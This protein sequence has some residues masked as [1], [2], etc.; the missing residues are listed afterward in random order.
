M[1]VTFGAALALAGFAILIAVAALVV[2]WCNGGR[3]F[4]QAASAMLIGMALIAYPAYLAYLAYTL[5]AIH[6]IT[7]DP[8]DPPRFD[9]VARLRPPNSSVY[10]GLATAELQKETWPDIEP[11]VVN[12][13]PKAAYDGAMN[14]ITKR[15]WRVVDSRP[16]EPGRDGHIEAIARSLIMGFRDDVVVRIRPAR[17]GATVDIRSARAL[18]PRRPRRQRQT[19]A[20][21]D[22]RHRRRG[23][24]RKTGAAAAPAKAGACN[25]CRE[26]GSARCEAI[27]GVERGRTAFGRDN[28]TC[29]QIFEVSER[30]QA[31]GPDEARI[32]PDIDRADEARDVG[33]SCAKPAQDRRFARQPVPDI[34]GNKSLRV[35]DHV[36]M[37]GEVN[38]LRPRREPVQ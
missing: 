5:P 4:M 10:P 19:R 12:A 2:L 21:A 22:R 17:Q 28:S 33:F 14:V 30:R 15:K 31:R 1:L 27:A 20:R 35:A 16:P 29:H 23:I 7:T 38:A 34:G 13:T 24:C 36:A 6:D 8:I 37:A 3:G 32:D 26:A 25:G 11:L 18:R 9:I